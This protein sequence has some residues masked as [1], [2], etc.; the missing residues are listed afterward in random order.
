MINVCRTHTS[1]GGLDNLAI[2]EMSKCDD[3]K[4]NEYCCGIDN[5]SVIDDWRYFS[6]L[7]MIAIIINAVF[8]LPVRDDEV[9]S[10]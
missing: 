8:A 5:F 6:I 3:D 7:D 10:A 2:I 9:M 1:V 4:D